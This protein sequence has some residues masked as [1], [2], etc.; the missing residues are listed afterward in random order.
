[1]HSRRETLPHSR[2][3]NVSG[4]GKSDA[5]KPRRAMGA[6]EMEM[7]RAVWDAPAG[8]TATEA[9]DV[10]GGDL[11]HTTAMTVLTRLWQKKVVRREREGKAFRYVH[12]KTEAEWTVER[13]RAALDAASNRELAM[14]GFVRSL[15]EAEADALRTLLKSVDR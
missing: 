6:L 12:A 15:D 10:L 8:L 5:Q 13:M 1:M 14:T 7:L 9:V 11:A 2:L 3:G 4:V